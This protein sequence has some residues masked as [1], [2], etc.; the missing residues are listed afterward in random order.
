MSESPPVEEDQCARASPLYGY[1]RNPLH[2]LFSGAVSG[3]FASLLTTPLDVMRTRLQATPRRPNGASFAVEISGLAKD[4][5]KEAG[6]R[7]FYRGVSPTMIALIPN[8][9]I[10]FYTYDGI[11]RR[12]VP[13]TGDNTVITNIIG[14]I[15][16]GAMTTVAVNPLWRTRAIL[17]TNTHEIG[18]KSTAG[19]LRSILEREGVRGLFKG[20]SPSLL[21]LIHV[22]INLPLFEYFRDSF[23]PRPACDEGDDLPRPINAVALVEATVLAKS[24]ASTV[25][26]PH[27]VLRTR[28]YLKE[29]SAKPGSDG[30]V[31]EAR[32]IWAEEGMRGFYRGL[33]ISLIRT[34]PATVV[35]FYTREHL[36]KWL[37]DMSL[38]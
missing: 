6:L 21:G 2:S 18:S 22:G 34:I 19:V 7:G 23:E 29:Q 11:R 5:Y 36:N 33:G 32:R 17:M 38:Q 35:V 3:V 8:W 1:H 16:A 9:G 37:H 30:I 20:L 10:F 28:L 26:Y 15:T 12:L 27:E 24:V 14:S 4:I 31:Q 13:F 25:T